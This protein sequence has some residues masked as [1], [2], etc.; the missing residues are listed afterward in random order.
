MS[1]NRNT[2]ARFRLK[3][4]VAQCV[5]LL[6]GIG[7]EEV[8]EPV[9]QQHL[10]GM[11]MKAFGDVFEFNYRHAQICSKN[12]RFPQRKTSVPRPS[13]ETETRLSFQRLEDGG[14]IACIRM[15]RRQNTR[16]A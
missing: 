7:P 1:D 16:L 12:P 2:L 9:A 3:R 11:A 14:D 4:D 13:I 10:A 5:K 6:P 15:L 8:R